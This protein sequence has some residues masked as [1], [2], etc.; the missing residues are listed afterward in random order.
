MSKKIQLIILMCGLSGITQA[1]AMTWQCIATDSRANEWK[2]E[3]SYQKN[4]INNAR[5]L[6]KQESKEPNSCKTSIENC[7]SFLDSISTSP[8][9]RCTALDQMAMVWKSEIYRKADD[10]ALAAK[11]FC[12]ERSAMP[13]TCYTYLFFCKNLNP[14]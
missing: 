7:D 13:E 12:M 9:W 5:D 14:L 3:G 1:Y 4:A 6:C 2:G 11:A 10:A 8:L